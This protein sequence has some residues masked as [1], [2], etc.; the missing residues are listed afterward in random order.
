MEKEKKL[1]TNQKIALER[2]YRLFELAQKTGEEKYVKRY[3]KLAKRIS[4]KCRVS[5]PKEL[6]KKYCKKCFSI[7]VNQTEQEPFL[8]IKCKNCGY[9]KKYSLQN[10]KS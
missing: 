10:E 1:K 5:I 2:I 6:K 9:E 4:E 8:L 3:L 7:K